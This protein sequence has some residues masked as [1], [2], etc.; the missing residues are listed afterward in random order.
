MNARTTLRLFGPTMRLVA[1]M[2]SVTICSAIDNGFT[3]PPMGWSALYGAPFNQV[4]ET[5]VLEAAK[6]L[7]VS[8]LLSLGYE[9]VVLDDWY[10]A[11][12]ENGRIIAVPDKFPSGMPKTSEIVHSLGCKFGVYSAASERTCANYSASLFRESQDVD[13]FANEWKIDYLKYDSC[14]YNAGVQSRL[15]YQ[16]M[17]RALNASGRQIFYSV[18]GWNPGDGNW[19]PELA[20]M[21]RTGSDIWPNWDNKPNCIL[22]NVYQTNIAAPYHKVGS[23]FNDPD[24]LQPP[25]TLKTVLSPGLSPEESA[26]QFKLWVIMKAPLILGVNYAQVA[27]LKS[28][29][30]SYYSLITNTEMIAI[31]QDLS[32]Q[33]RVVRQFPSA[34]QQRGAGNAPGPVNV[35]LQPCDMSRA[36]QRFAANSQKGLIEMT[37]TDMCL[38]EDTKM[39]TLVATPCKGAHAYTLEEDE[40]LSVVKSAT[41]G[42]C[43]T[44]TPGAAKPSIADCVYD[45][46]MP[47]PLNVVSDG[48]L[49]EQTFLWG[50]TT[51]QIVAGGTGMCLT[52]GEPNIDPDSRTWVTNNGTLE[53][54]VWMGSLTPSKDGTPRRVVALFNKGLEIEVLTAPADLI[55]TEG[56]SGPVAIRNVVEQKDM[57]PLAVGADLE[58]NVP[59]HGVAVFILSV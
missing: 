42:K 40:T 36:D 28:L 46:P 51:Q 27:D 24:M 3:T 48:Q 21:W 15:R 58:F 9:Y 13:V 22:R 44:S 56:A 1:L 52:V 20:N 30:P 17:Q 10:A 35:T 47:P 12:D 23:G 25:N 31:D 32:E 41:A 16:A 37:G 43:W 49:G 11:R 55:G 2:S 38:S 5:M 54:E 34:A 39:Q 8:G 33:A 6:G 19:G 18:E 57:E 59:S 50:S 53:H 4:N 14:L 45:G 26:S 7:N 29:D